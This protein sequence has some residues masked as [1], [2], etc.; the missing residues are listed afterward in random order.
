MKGKVCI[1]T[2][3][4]SGI[5]KE[6][7][8][9]LA[10]KGATVILA[11]RNREK[12][13]EA[14]RFIVAETGSEKISVM[15]CDV[16]SGDSIKEFCK[17]FN[18]GYTR[19]NVLINNAGA[20][21]PKRQL[22]PEGFELTFATNYLGPF[23]LTHE[24]LPILKSSAPSRIVNVGSGM[25]KTGKLDFDNL[26]SQKKFNTMSVYSNSKLWLTMQTYELARRLEGTGVTANVV[27]PGFVATNLG[28]NSG[29]F[30]TS[31]MFRVVRF[32]QISSKK[33]AET[34]VYAASATELETVTGKIF[35]K[36]KEIQSSETS[37]D[38][39]LQRRLWEETEKLLGWSE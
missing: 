31:L 13:E 27:E 3:S 21:F 14:K 23:Q 33:G 39:E 8:L 34:S 6:T 26:Q 22:T 9:A 5:G 35:A 1:V 36:S 4:N 7:A 15:G 30:L 2:G 17:E 29:S 11:V 38:P 32:M 18:N 37:Y 12:G 28:M 10:E 19:L 25:H 16:S 24:L 20:V